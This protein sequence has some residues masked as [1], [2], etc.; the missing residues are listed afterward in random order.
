MCEL[1]MRTTQPQ[2]KYLELSNFAMASVPDSALRK[3]RLY[4]LRRLQNYFVDYEFGKLVVRKGYT[5]WNE[6]PLPAPGTQIYVF[7]ASNTERILVIS[8]NK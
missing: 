1:I 7:Q 2:I 5:K 4:T 3:D 8:G 6:K